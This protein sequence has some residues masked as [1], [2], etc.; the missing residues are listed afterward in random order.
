MSKIDTKGT[1]QE[2][3]KDST[4]KGVGGKKNNEGTNLE[5]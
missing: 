1:T 3:R 5:K 2:N 4:K